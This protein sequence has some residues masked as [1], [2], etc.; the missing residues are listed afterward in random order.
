MPAPVA[1]AVVGSYLLIGSDWRHSPGDLSPSPPD[2]M[3]TLVEVPL[4][5]DSTTALPCF[6]GSGETTPAAGCVDLGAAFDQVY[7]IAA[8]PD[9]DAIAVGTSFRF[10]LELFHRPSMDGGAFAFDLCIGGLYICDRRGAE[11]VAAFSADESHLYT[12]AA[13]YCRGLPIPGDSAY[14]P[15]AETLTGHPAKPNGDTN[16]IPTAMT[17]SPDGATVYLTFGTPSGFPTKLGG[18]YVLHAVG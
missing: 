13:V 5:S 3:S 7:S 18:I 11:D 16:V 12:P 1:L 10:D 14:M 8:A 17:T 2:Y 6:T 4:Y 9:G 15:C